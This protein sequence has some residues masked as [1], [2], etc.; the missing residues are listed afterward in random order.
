MNFEIFDLVLTLWNVKKHKRVSNEINLIVLNLHIIF[1]LVLK[2]YYLF[3]TFFSN[4]FHSNPTINVLYN[5]NEVIKHPKQ[6][7]TIL[8]I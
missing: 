6:S 5:I 3:N 2:R 7:F 8:D 4:S 1:L